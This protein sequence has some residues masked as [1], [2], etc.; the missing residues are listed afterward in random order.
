MG[1]DI[2]KSNALIEAS[3]KPS[4]LYQMRLL[5][6]ALSQIKAGEKLSYKKEFTITAGGL[7]EMTGTTIRANY[8]HLAR[9]ADELMEM[10]ITVPYR[11]NGDERRLVK[12]RINVVGQCDYIE[13]EGCVKLEFTPQIIPYISA[14]A[15]H[16]TVYKAQY[17][18]SMKSG[19]SI[20]LYELCLQWLGFGSERE[21]EVDEFKEK[22]GLSDK[23]G[24]VGFLN[25]DVIKPAIKEINKHTNIHVKLGQRK[26]GRRIT[27]LQFTITK[28]A[29][30]Q[31]PARV[32]TSKE[33]R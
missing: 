22:M 13:K 16:F 31:A 32:R 19:Y 6:A 21:F 33:S 1:K 9:A 10:I 8:R 4:S 24:S 2:V 26:A 29:A 23:Y 20:R 18:M 15:S 25:R 12:R 11:P 30:A 17:V 3:Y 28:Q 5:I 27:H 7:A 14:L